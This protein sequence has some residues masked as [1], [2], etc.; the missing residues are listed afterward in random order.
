MTR[1]SQ[2]PITSGRNSMSVTGWRFGCM[3]NRMTAIAVLVAMTVGSAA[4]ARGQSV[5]YVDADAVGAS[6]GTSWSASPPRETRR[7]V[8]RKPGSAM[9]CLR[10]HLSD[11]DS[12]HAEANY[13]VFS[14]RPIPNH[15]AP[16]PRIRDA[17]GPDSMSETRVYLRMD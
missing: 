15:T 2:T 8:S 1:T 4:V 3:G 11:P 12:D 14:I 17:S 9:V 5:V 6:N 16:H 10:F 13:T 7:N